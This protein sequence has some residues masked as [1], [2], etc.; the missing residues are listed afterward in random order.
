MNRSTDATLWWNMAGIV[1]AYQPIG[2]PGPLIARYNQARGGQNRYTLI[3]TAP[4]TWSAAA[5]WI[6]AGAHYFNTG[7]QH[8]D[9]GR[10]WSLICRF[11][12][13]ANQVAAQWLAAD[14]VS[15][16]GGF[17]LLL[18]YNDYDVIKDSGRLSVAKHTA[19]VYCIA[20]GVPYVDGVVAGAIDV[21][22]Q[23]DAPI[24]MGR[25]ES[26]SYPLTGNI[27]ALAVYNRPLSS[28]E[29]WSV[30]RQMQYCEK[31]PEWSVW[32]VPR[33]ITPLRYYPATPANHRNRPLTGVG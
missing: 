5:G 6:F 11:S 28:F 1:A 18:T 9:T 21:Q 26:G 8:S 33:L 23:Y 29:V 25:C 2:A 10:A 15:R 3:T 19:A 14:S 20:G 30:T 31:N 16:Y 32:S 22:T 27:Q 12:D 4:P 17:G 13:A 24:Y 7:I